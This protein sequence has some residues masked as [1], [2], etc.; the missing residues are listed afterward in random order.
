MLFSERKRI[1]PWN[2]SPACLS[3]GCRE[4]ACCSGVSV[5][6]SLCSDGLKGLLPSQEKELLVQRREISERGLPLPS[7]LHSALSRVRLSVTPRTAARQASLSI[8]NSRS[9]LKVTS[10][11][12][13]M[14]CN[15]LILCL[16]LL[17][18]S[19]FPSGRVFSSL[20]Q[21]QVVNGIT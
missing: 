15:R 20:S 8:T 6:C 10:I 14:P 3:R 19:V 5:Q 16:P 1:S 13:V 17:L 21:Q 9:S 4:P 2:T 12:S 7:H 18:P 11:E